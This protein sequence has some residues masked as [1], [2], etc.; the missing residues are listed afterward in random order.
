GIAIHEPRYWS[1]GYG[2]DAVEVMVDAAFRVLPLQR[3]ELLVLPDNAR[4]IR[5]YEN[6]G[7]KREGLLRSYTYN[8]GRM[9]DMIIMSILHE[10]WGRGKDRAR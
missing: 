10:E 6:A 9:Q 1:Q 5:C 4:A 2:Q 8:R 3:I 7:F